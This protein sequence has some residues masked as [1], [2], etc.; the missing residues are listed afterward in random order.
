MKTVLMI[1]YNFPPEGSAG[2][3]RPL[4]FVRHLPSFGWLPIVI[5]LATDVYGRYDPS[6]L[7]MVPR[8]TEVIRVRNPDLWNALQQKRAKR[9]ERQLSVLPVEKIRKIQMAHQAPL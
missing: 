6:L 7:D 9:I 3:Y 5:S 4:R 1:A 2:A 8:D